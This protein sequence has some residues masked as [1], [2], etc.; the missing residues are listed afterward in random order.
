MQYAKQP[1]E[2]I[3][4]SQ[5]S[6]FSYFNKFKA[7]LKQAYKDG[8]LSYDLNARI[9][10]IKE[11][12]THRNFLTL[13]ELNTLVKK[14]CLNPV[15]KNAALFSALTGF[16]FGDIA[17][18]IWGEV[19]FIKDN[20]YFIQFTQQ[21]TNG[22]EMM[23]ISD[24]AYK[25]MGERRNPDQRVFDGLTYSAYSN[26]HLAQWIGSA[27][28]TKNITFHCF[29]HTYAILQL[30]L[31]TEFYTVSKMLGHRDPRTTASRLTSV[32]LMI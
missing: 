19:E 26:K 31:G 30:S 17:K 1:S 20:G 4:L 23:P 10:R 11:T 28:I 22:A 9:D 8:Y 7:T 3:K 15:L 18:M 24:Q 12:E 29:R 6:A 13:D 25:L 21:K 27:G 2:K 32:L 14:D 5:N 16:R